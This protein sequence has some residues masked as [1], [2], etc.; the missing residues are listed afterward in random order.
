MS[1]R[2]VPKGEI[3][4]LRS[5]GFTLLEVLLSMAIL[6]VIM[7]V[8]YASFSTAGNNVDQAERRREETDIGRTL[9]ARLSAD[10]AN[11]YV[12]APNTAIQGKKVEVL[13]EKSENDR[14]IRHDSIAL[15]TLTNFPRPNTKE[16]ELWEVEYFFKEK[17][18]GS[19]YILYRREKR[20]L[21][22]DA[23][24]EGGV[25]YEITDRVE[26]LLFR[27]LDGTNVWKDDGWNQRTTLPKA[28]EIV[29]TLDSGKVYATRVDV[30]NAINN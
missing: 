22:K 13:G 6:A 1:S 2:A 12:K 17:P 30:G 19:G 11:A 29:L 18:D 3:R 14:Q 16:T 23:P 25:E 27:Y 24:L 5:G 4:G 7:T 8:I 21:S 10:I 15:P 28:V 26:S 20:D 9:M